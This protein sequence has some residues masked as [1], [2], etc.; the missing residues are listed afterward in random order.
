M[1]GRHWVLKKGGNPR[2][3][4]TDYIRAA[5]I[6][7]ILSDKNVEKNLRSKGYNST[8]IKTALRIRKLTNDLVTIEARIAA[9]AANANP[10]NAN[11]ANTNVHTRLAIAESK[12]IACEKELKELK[13]KSFV[14]RLRAKVAAAE[15]GNKTRRTKNTK[16]RRFTLRR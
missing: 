2:D 3:F 1:G 12:V 5:G 7:G 6:V 11:P 10:A 13:A 8:T 14:V 16:R 15:G 4:I 9:N